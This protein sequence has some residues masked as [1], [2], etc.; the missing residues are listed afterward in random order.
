M[1]Q[2][3][4]G[5]TYAGRPIEK[6]YNGLSNGAIF[7][8]LERPQPGFQCHSIWRWI[9]QKRYEIRSNL[10]LPRGKGMQRST[11]RWGD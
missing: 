2:H 5:N 4:Q 11:S 9:S 1:V 7:K 3:R 6:S 8:D 10:N